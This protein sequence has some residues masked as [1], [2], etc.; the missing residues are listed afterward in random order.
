[1]PL[2]NIC[3][4]SE[5]QQAVTSAVCPQYSAVLEPLQCG[6]HQPRGDGRPDG[7]HPGR[8]GRARQVPEVS[9]GADCRPTRRS[10]EVQTIGPLS[11]SRA[12]QVQ[13]VSRG[14]DYRPTEPEPCPSGSGGQ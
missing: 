7:D 1:M 13:E 3:D 10:V 4:T 14:A 2:L 11:Q 5:A 6:Q 12:R 8:Q 9:R